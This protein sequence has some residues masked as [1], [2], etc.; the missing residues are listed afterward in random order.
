[1]TNAL[2][3]T[4][5]VD[6]TPAVRT[7]M[8]PEIVTIG[9]DATLREAQRIFEQ[10]RLHHLI[11]LEGERAVGVISD[12]D[13]L[14]HL[15]PFVGVP[16]SERGQDVRT[17]SRPIHRIMTRKLISISPD[18]AV[19]EAARRM[20]ENRVSC[21]PVIDREKK[22]VGIITIRDLVRWAIVAAGQ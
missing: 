6:R 22:L 21:L 7:W 20:I 8:T 19:A 11:V 14:K 9:L 15:S 1:M 5:L 3:C 4:P 12:R 10:R 16:I 13:L 17:L 18:A 2:F